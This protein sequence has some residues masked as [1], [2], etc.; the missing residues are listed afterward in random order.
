MKSKS[1][2]FK[3]IFSTGRINVIGIP[4]LWI[5][6]LGWDKTTKLVL[7]YHPYKKEIVILDDYRN[8][9][10]MKIKQ[11]KPELVEVSVE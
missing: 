9:S 1:V 11:K 3:H 5:N 7:E 8:I 2:K 10:T 6:E 4:Q